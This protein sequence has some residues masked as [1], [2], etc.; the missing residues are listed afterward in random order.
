LINPPPALA[1]YGCSQIQERCQLAPGETAQPGYTTTMT[2]Q[3][4]A[5]VW[6]IV[7]HDCNAVVSSAPP[8]SVLA[9]AEVQRLVPRPAIGVG[10]PGGVSLV[11]IQTLFWLT[12]PATQ[13]LGSV[14]LLGQTVQLQA[15]VS[16]VAWDFGDGHTDHT[17]NPGTPY[18]SANPCR[19]ALCP[20]YFGHVYTDTGSRTVTATVT[21]TGSYR[22]GGGAWQPIAG[23]VTGLPSTLALTVKQARGVLVPDPDGG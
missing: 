22:V 1:G 14:Q 18:S 11:N 23:T 19:T 5:G 20:G 2:L 15:S 10:P 9:H 12:T 4:T 3:L 7:A 6:E 8:I 16:D 17:D 13:A 21:W